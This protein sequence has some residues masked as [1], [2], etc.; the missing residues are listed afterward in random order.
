MVTVVPDTVQTPVVDDV[1]MGSS[2]DVADT[3]RPNVE[4][5]QVFV[6]G[7]ANEIVLVAF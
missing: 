2:R 3:T 1:T 5:D 4:L 6:P 7:F